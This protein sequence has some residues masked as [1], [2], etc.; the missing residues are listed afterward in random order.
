MHLYYTE[1]VFIY[2]YTVHT[3]FCHICSSRSQQSNK[4]FFFITDR[5]CFSSHFSQIS[6]VSDR[7]RFCH[8]HEITSFT[9]I[10][11]S[12]LTN[13]VAAPGTPTFQYHNTVSQ[14]GK[15]SKDLQSFT[16]NT[17]QLDRPFKECLHW[18]PIDTNRSVFVF[19][20]DCSSCIYLTYCSSQ[21]W[22]QLG[23]TFGFKLMYY[24]FEKCSN[25]SISNATK[26]LNTMNSVEGGFEAKV[27]GLFFW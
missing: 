2:V 9:S 11:A 26:R 8:D 5:L 23:S 25:A 16:Y 4:F 3:H 14:Y 15:I 13:R 7:S 17:S 20:S 1:V 22:N 19:T 6:S 27:W 21:T 12:H 24:I 10:V 18:Q